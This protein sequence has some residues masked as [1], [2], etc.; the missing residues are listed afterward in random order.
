MAAVRAVSEDALSFS[1]TAFNTDFIF[2]LMLDFT[3]AFLSRVFSLYLLLL[4]AD[5]CIAK[6]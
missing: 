5:L 6:K 4:I 2:V 3:E 1:S